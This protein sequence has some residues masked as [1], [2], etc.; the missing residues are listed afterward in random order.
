M[1]LETRGQPRDNCA[2]LYDA[3]AAVKQAEDNGEPTN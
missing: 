1:S 3:S 2:R